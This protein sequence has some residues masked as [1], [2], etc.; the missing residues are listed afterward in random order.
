MEKLIIEA[1]HKAFDTLQKQIPKTINKINNIDISDVDP[2]D[3]ATLLKTNN[4]LHGE[5]HFSW[6]DDSLH[7]C[8]WEK[9]V[10][11]DDYILE[12][13]RNVFSN[14]AW[15]YIY[16][17]LTNNNYIRIGFDSNLLK[18]F[19]PF[20]PTMIY[21]WYINKDFDTL[22]KFYSFRFHDENIRDLITSKLLKY[23]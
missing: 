2:C 13:K 20:Q 23:E 4:L 9:E 15:T 8:W 21:D 3:L 12:F 16:K 11:T 7:L 17:S 19:K 22:V 18:Q 6:D 1:L 10:P 5:S 14:I